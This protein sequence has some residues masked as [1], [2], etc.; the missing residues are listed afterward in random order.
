[1]G[2]Y[3]VFYLVMSKLIRTFVKKLHIHLVIFSFGFVYTNLIKM[4]KKEIK[5]IG[6]IDFKDIKVNVYNDPYTHK[7][8]IN[9]VW[10]MR[11]PDTCYQ[12]IAYMNNETG[13]ISY[14]DDAV[15]PEQTDKDREMLP[16]FVI[17]GYETIDTKFISLLVPKLEESYKMRNGL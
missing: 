5:L 2:V 8:I 7:D 3:V 13:K 14:P 11:N 12:G 4:G 6:S 1:L 10:Q 15:I 16:K 17:T 9:C